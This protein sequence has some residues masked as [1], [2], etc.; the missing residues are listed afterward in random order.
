[1]LSVGPLRSAG[2]RFPARLVLLRVEPDIPIMIPA[3]VWESRTLFIPPRHWYR[4]RLNERRLRGPDSPENQLRSCLIENG[5]D[6]EISGITRIKR[7][8]SEWDVCKVHLPNQVRQNGTEPDH[9]IGLF[10]RLELAE[11]VALPFISFGHSCHFG[12][13]QFV[14]VL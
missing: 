5:V 10:L 7:T 8:N 2:G 11:S 12:L 9:R 6:V 4:K 13:G 1:M 3:T 14:P